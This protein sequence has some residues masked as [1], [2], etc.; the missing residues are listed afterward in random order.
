LA[1]GSFFSGKIIDAQKCDGKKK[2]PA[3]LL[4]AGQIGVLRTTIA[5]ETI[6]RTATIETDLGLRD[7]PPP[8]GLPRETD[9]VHA[10]RKISAL[11]MAGNL[12]VDAQMGATIIEREDSEKE[13]G[14]R[15]ATLTP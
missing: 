14:I 7:V 11:L 12:R 5:A 6:G 9:A 15:D 4:H 10:H 2:L 8:G 1:P 3:G 13:N